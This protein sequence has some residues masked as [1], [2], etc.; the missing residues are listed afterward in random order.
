VTFIIPDFTSWEFSFYLGD[1]L[2]ANPSEKVH[3]SLT[4]FVSERKSLTFFESSNL[5][6][7]DGK[8]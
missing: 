6:R 1:F 5:D 8:V 2:V 7:E 3:F 4:R